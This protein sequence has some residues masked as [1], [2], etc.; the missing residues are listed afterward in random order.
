MKRRI[1]LLL[2]VLILLIGFV[3]SEVPADSAIAQGGYE[4]N[5]W[6]FAGAGGPQSGGEVQMNATLGQPVIVGAQGGSI[7]LSA[8]YWYPRTGL[9][10]LFLP[11]LQK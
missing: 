4:L 2:L 7:V 11:L 3:G 10:Q 1:V 8:G 5:W 6:V 9:F